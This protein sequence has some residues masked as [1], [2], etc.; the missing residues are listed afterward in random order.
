[1]YSKNTEPPPTGSKRWS[2]LTKQIVVVG[3]LVAGVWALFRFSAVLSPLVIAL[4]LA[5]LITPL[6]NTV[7]QRTRVH[8]TLVLVVVYALILVASGLATALIVPGLI[9]QFAAL[10]LDLQGTIASAADFLARPITFFGYSI[11][12][13]Q[14][15]GQIISTIQ[16]LLSPFATGAVGVVFGIAA[17]FAWIVFILVT[18]FYVAKDSRK[19]ARYVRGLAPPEY[20]EEYI[21][22]GS[23]I[24]VIWG[25]FLRGQLVLAFV[26]GSA[27]AIIV[28]ALGLRNGVTLGLLAG[29]LE[30]IPYFGPILAAIPA[31]LLAFFQGSSYLPV[32]DAWFAVIIA[33]TYII[34]QQIEN[35][36]L[37]PRIIGRSVK[38]HPVVVLI[39]VTA[40]ATIGGFLG[41]LLAAPIIATVR[42][43]GNYAYRKV[44]DLEPFGEALT[45]VAEPLVHQVGMIGGRDVEGVLF[46]LDGTLIDT[47]DDLV[48]RWASR[49]ESIEPLLPSHDAKRSVRR[50]ISAGQ[51]PANTLLTLLDRMG[52]D[53][54]A[55]AVR[56]RLRQLAGQPPTDTFRLIDGVP[57]LLERLG[58]RFSLAIVTTRSREEVD[59][60]LEQ[61]GWQDRFQAVVTR[62]DVAHLKPDPEAI[63][64]AA[65]KLKIPV[66][67]CAMVGDTSTDIEAAQNA[68]AIAIGVLSGFGERDDLGE[69]DLVL[70]TTADLNAWL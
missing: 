33:G 28:S 41:V 6:V 3:G 8:R 21:E 5:Y 43:L 18:S 24:G 35:N 46:D 20:R 54:E 17:S 19:I 36:Y 56:G 34:I 59:A 58:D 9:N 31:I 64:L 40:G 30:W 22:L 25:R 26:V 23:Q 62:D 69:A 70:E 32:S 55:L 51:K 16:G 29:I 66:G 13:S 7:H 12:S 52:F 11:E 38:L 27:V 53:D 44:L 37:V 49:L 10:N 68:G 50:T 47:D 45:S 15:T 2:A 61:F 1:M 42:V 60:F 65:E 57:E 48:A 67:R 14:F 4:L 39:G 63:L